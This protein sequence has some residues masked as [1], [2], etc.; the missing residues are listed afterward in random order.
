MEYLQMSRNK[1]PPNVPP[2]LVF[3]LENTM[4]KYY[5]W[6]AATCINP[7]QWDGDNY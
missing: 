1:I 2:N 6:L 3:K 5:I 4:N 7:V